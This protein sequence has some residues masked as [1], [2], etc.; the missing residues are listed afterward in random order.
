ML[1]RRLKAFAKTL[2][3]SIARKNL[4]EDLPRFLVAQ[5]G[6]MFAV[7]LVT[8][9][10]GIFKG[11]IQSTATL[12]DSSAADIWVGSENLAAL[13]MTVPIPY[14]RL[15]QAQK[16]EGVDKA[17]ALV[18]NGSLWRNALG[19]INHVRIFGFDPNGELFTPGTV[20]KGRLSD[21]EKPYRVLIDRRSFDKLK[22]GGWK[23][24]VVALGGFETT[25]AG[26][27]TD[28]QCAISS[29]FV[30]TSLENANAYGTAKLPPEPLSGPQPEPLKLTTDDNIAYVLVR[31]KP[32]VDLNL[33]KHR[34]E[35]AMPY[36]RAYTK[37][38]MAEKTRT[39]WERRTGIGFILGL[40]AGV[41]LI[42]GVVVVG[43]ILYS[44]VSDHLKEFGTLKAI[45]ASN[46]TIYSV[47]IEQSLWMA[48]MG[49]LPGMALCV[50]VRA[51][52]LA[53]QGLLISIS[54]PTAAGV[55]GITVV[56]CISA[57][58]FAIHKVNRVDPAIVFKA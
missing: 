52:V 6:I 3:P 25:V 26:F 2:M 9:Q 5:A 53:S 1:P 8:I 42:V 44:S 28:T 56:M 19:N 47:I 22:V 11:V 58:I 24:E 21:L 48:V 17:E 49:Y 43:Q 37:A 20:T 39:Y 30:F 7:S 15:S 10:T 23:Q 14:D 31:A 33:L 16:V 29:P 55:F 54:V 12:I 27:T 38:E 40:G 35:Q 57:A 51:W 50:G 13:E 34:L 46:V 18:M 32:G 36:T 45:G 4:F 41:G